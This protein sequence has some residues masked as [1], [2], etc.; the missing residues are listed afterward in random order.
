MDQ[1]VTKAR[2]SVPKAIREPTKGETSAAPPK[3]G[4]ASATAAQ[5]RS[6]RQLTPAS[7]VI[8]GAG[9]DLTRRLVVPALCHLV[10]AKELPDEF[11][12]IGVDHNDRTTEQWRQMLTEWMRDS[13]SGDAVEEDV[14]SWLVQRMHY[15]RGDFTEPETFT[16]LDTLLN[17]QH[18]RQGGAETCCSTSRWAIGS[19]VRSS[20]TSV[21]PDSRASP[22]T[23]GGV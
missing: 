13:S 4:G 20:I 22:R 1:D 16:R 23:P 7:M 15:M 11:A 6:G 9:G 14:C 19:S 12:V 8:F 3:P 2:A 17:E 5:Y 18:S 10:R 21:V